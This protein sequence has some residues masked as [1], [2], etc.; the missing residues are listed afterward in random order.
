MFVV[1]ST[2]RSR[3]VCR[4]N[5]KVGPAISVNEQHLTDRALVMYSK[6]LFKLDLINLLAERV[7]PID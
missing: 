1:A 6:E 3:R 7:V 2:K 5:L 4:L